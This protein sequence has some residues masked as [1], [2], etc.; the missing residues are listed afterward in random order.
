MNHQ[1]RLE[2]CQR[3]LQD[4]VDHGTSKL[5]EKDLESDEQPIIAENIEALKVSG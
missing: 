3:A 2:Q 1:Q 4:V 5:A